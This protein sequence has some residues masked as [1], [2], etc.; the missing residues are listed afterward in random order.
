MP[1]ALLVQDR[2]NIFAENEN[3]VGVIIG[4][5]P[6]LTTEQ[7]EK[8][9]HLKRFGANRAF[10]FD[11]DVIA[12]CN[13][14]FWHH[15][16]DQIKDYRCHKWATLDY[17]R[18]KHLDVNYIESRFMDGLSVD[19]NYIAHHH[20]TGPQLINLALHYGCKVML[21]IGWDMRYPGK[22]DRY[23][24]TGNRHYFGE[25]PA[26]L[27]HW[28][29]YTAADGRLDGLMK[30]LVTIKPADYGIE[31]I[32]CTPNSAM[33]CFPAMSLDEALEKYT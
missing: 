19:K 2:F 15:Y 18:V 6:S 9:K 14:E 32:N 12:A 31:I 21:L 26:E 5:G 24:Y 4:T 29:I 25:Y 23:N 17:E 22:I 13:W 28:P 33:T 8:V 20:G 11:L 7:L 1:P 10:E 27:Q 3:R 30:E 16:W